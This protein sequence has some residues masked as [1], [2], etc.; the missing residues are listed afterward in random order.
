MTVEEALEIV[1]QILKQGHLS[2]VQE[3]TFR[4]SWE[5]RSYLE[6]ASAT[7]YDPGYIKDTGSK[8]WQLLS[9]ALEVRVTKQNL[10]AVLQ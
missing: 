9:V 7:S 5:G 4:Q 10:K 6:I 3:L 8:L 2:K 1:K